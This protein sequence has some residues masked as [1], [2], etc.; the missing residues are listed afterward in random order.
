MS[1]TMGIVRVA[2]ALM[3]AVLVG[4]GI[5]LVASGQPG[6]WLTVLIGAGGL[7][8][9]LFERVR[10]RSE[11][12]ERTTRRGPDLGG[13]ESQ[14]PGEPFVSTPETFIDPTTRQRT[15][16]YVDPSTGERRYHAEP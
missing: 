13:A 11:A 5:S 16:V 4:V 12:A 8:G 6:A 3:S 1:M 7:F 15:R 2:I 9:V 10:Y 14:P